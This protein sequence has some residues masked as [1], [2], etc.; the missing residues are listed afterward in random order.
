VDDGVSSVSSLTELDDVSETSLGEIIMLDTQCQHE[1]KDDEMAFG[2]DSSNDNRNATHPVVL[3]R[4]GYSS[5]ET[6]LRKKVQL[7]EQQVNRLMVRKAEG[8]TQSENTIERLE[9]HVRKLNARLGIFTEREG[10]K[11]ESTADEDLIDRLIAQLH[12]RDKEIRSLKSSLNEALG[13]NELLSSKSNNI[14]STDLT[15]S[16]GHLMYQIESSTIFAADLL[17]QARLSRPFKHSRQ[18]EIEALIL[19]SIGTVNLL[20]SH[21]SAAFRAMIFKFVRD[22]IFYCAD[23]WSTLHFESL[24]LR[25]YQKTLQQGGKFQLRS[26]SPNYFNIDR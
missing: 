2:S 19:D 8:E 20:Q 4:E 21:S 14:Y 3:D 17:C 23:L 13:L 9:K 1:E 22:R 6:Y 5:T 12:S 10:T 24:M 26:L 11:P 15:K 16:T 7:L 18:E 25:V